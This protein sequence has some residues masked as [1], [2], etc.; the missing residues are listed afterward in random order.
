[1]KIRKIYCQ[2]ALVRSHL[3]DFCL[4]PY[5]GCGHGCKY[6]YAI[7]IQK[8]H[9]QSEEWGS[10]VDVKI[11]IAEVL[12][13]ELK[14]I[15]LG[16]VLIGSV[17]D[18]YQPLESQFKLTRKCLEKF[19]QVGFEGEL[20]ILTKSAL[21]LRDL[22]LLK[23]F[24]NFKVGL[25]LTS[26]NNQISRLFEPQ[27]SLPELRLKALATLQKE[28]IKTYAFVGPLLPYFGDRRENLEELFQKIKKTGLK[29]LFVDKLNYGKGIVGK[30]LGPIYQAYG[31]QACQA[32]ADCDSQGYINKLRELVK[33]LMA[34]YK[35]EGQILF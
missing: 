14:K 11:N 25:T 19:L 17:T 15:R 4:N 9:H 28:G 23:K 1:M 21:V 32:L 26:L 8:W 33:S 5:L 20:S 34:K 27:A 16:T 2:S 10:F 30:R 7:F 22:D 12:E 6:C 35:L 29:Y 3:A 31:S 13:Q 24:K 18:P